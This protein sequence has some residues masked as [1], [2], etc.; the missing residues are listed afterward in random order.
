MDVREAIKSR[1]SVRAYEDRAISLD[2]VR[3]LIDAARLAPSWG[4]LQPWR[5]LLVSSE[6]EK[7]AMRKNEIFTQD[8]VYEAPLII[9][10]CADPGVFS[11][12]NSTEENTIRAV[13]DLSMAC[14]NLFLRATELELGTCCV[15]LLDRERIKLVL[16]IPK[17]YYIPYVITVGLPDE[18]PPAS[19]RKSARS[20]VL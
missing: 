12:K 14:E 19:P 8:F 6:K 1:R 9:V 2:L 4:N 10:A 16:K 20:I 3:K 18:D 5:F 11:R 13:S 7:D 17:K 15:G